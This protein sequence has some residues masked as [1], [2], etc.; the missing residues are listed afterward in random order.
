MM[1]LWGGVYV[2]FYSKV[3]KG[4]EEKVFSLFLFIS[5]LNVSSISGQELVRSVKWPVNVAIG[6][7]MTLQGA[8]L[9]VTSYM[10]GARSAR[11]M[12]PL[13]APFSDK[14][15]V[16]GAVKMGIATGTSFMLLR[17]HREHPKLAFVMAVIGSGVYSGVVYHNSKLLKK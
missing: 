5:L 16:F 7:Y 13:L 15:V 10:L 3:R 12:N 17:L 1:G 4:M 14:P 2:G 9:S 11:E 8:D 6:S